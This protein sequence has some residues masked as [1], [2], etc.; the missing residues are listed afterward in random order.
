MTNLPYEVL[1]KIANRLES[2]LVTT[3]P[4]DKG[5]LHWSIKV[6]FQGNTIIIT[7]LD[8]GY[9]V[10]FGKPPRISKAKKNKGKKVKIKRQRPNP[11]IRNA[12]NNKLPTIIQ[13][14]IQRYSG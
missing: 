7:M 11:F 13:E 9:Y 5:P 12:I 1:F 4:V 2:E 14:E 8:Y 3:C 10:E 6:K